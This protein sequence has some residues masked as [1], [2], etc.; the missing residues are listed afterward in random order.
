MDSEDEDFA[1]KLAKKRRLV[2]VKVWMLM[3]T[4]MLI[5]AGINIL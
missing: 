4:T 1:S 2:M 3:M 5:V